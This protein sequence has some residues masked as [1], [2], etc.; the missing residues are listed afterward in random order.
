M[1]CI[2]EA[3]SVLIRVCP[4]LAVLHLIAAFLAFV[5]LP[6]PFIQHWSFYVLGSGLFGLGCF[7]YPSWWFL[8]SM[9]AADSSGG[10]MD[11]MA[12]PVLFGAGVFICGCSMVGLVLTVAGLIAGFVEE[13]SGTM[14]IDEATWSRGILA[15]SLGVIWLAIIS[16]PVSCVIGMLRAKSLA[17]HPAEVF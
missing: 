2:E 13:R 1:G 7:S 12:L 15:T 14:G 5:P 8:S 10:C 4:I 9:F 16:L 11:A 17:A 6:N 3:A